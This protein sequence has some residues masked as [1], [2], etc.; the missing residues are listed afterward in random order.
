MNI[1]FILHET[2]ISRQV[3]SRQV[4]K[5]PYLRVGH[6]FI[7]KNRSV[8]N[9]VYHMI[10]VWFSYQVSKFYFFMGNTPTKSQVWTKTVRFINIAFSVSLS[11]ICI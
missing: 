7:T 11:G 4:N 2:I 6:A 10:N 8:H 9:R 5:C 3:I 1:S